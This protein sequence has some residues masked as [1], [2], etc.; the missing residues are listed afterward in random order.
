MTTHGYQWSSAHAMSPSRV[1][2]ITRVFQSPGYVF[3]EERRQQTGL[4]LPYYP[5]MPSPALKWPSN[6]SSLVLQEPISRKSTLDETSSDL[7]KMPTVR[8]DRKMDQQ[9]TQPKA[10]VT[11]VP[12]FSSLCHSQL[13]SWAELLTTCSTKSQLTKVS[14]SA[15]WTV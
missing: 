12:L 9:W 8:P 10:A 5:P 7:W 13:I 15:K 1:R 3:P 2:R 4:L 6:S 11:T 14:G